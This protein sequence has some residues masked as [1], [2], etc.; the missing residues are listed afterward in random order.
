MGRRRRREDARQLHGVLVLNKP[1]G[2]TSTD[3]LNRIKRELGQPII[4]HAGTL[5]PL[6]SGVLVVLLGK[7]TRL[8]T[9][10]LGARK[11]YQGA[12]RL[13][14]ATDTYDIQG[15]VVEER[16]CEGLDPEEIRRAVL[17][18]KGTS[19]QEVPAY[20]AAKHQGRPLYELARAGEEVPVK[21]KDVTVYTAE[22]LM[23]QP[24]EVAFRVA[25]SAG[26]Y[27]RSL[28][29]SLGKRLGCGA[30]MTALTREESEPFSLGQAHGLEETLSDPEG[31]GARVL[32]IAE[33]LNGWLQVELGP[34]EAKGVRNGMRIPVAPD[35][36]KSASPGVKAL[37]SEAGEPLALAEAR[38]LEGRLKWV[39]LRGL[40]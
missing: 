31:F 27:V 24:P 26:T 19:L 2:P 18:W 30:T 40:F 16:P 21:E 8:A 37:L 10:L 29:H 3:C 6:A 38:H 14:L 15:K 11:T 1:S 28:V 17:G 33:V 25:C 35:L 12:L 36:A 4:G 23:V 32:P 7:A 20:S 22:A 39:I 13:G 5:D 9:H 34:D